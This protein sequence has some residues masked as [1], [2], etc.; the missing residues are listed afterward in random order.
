MDIVE[1]LQALD[2]A[3]ERYGI[4]GRILGWEIRIGKYGQQVASEARATF[5]S[6]P[7]SI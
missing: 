1:Y 5:Q 3:I 2:V 7:S 6:E 4:S